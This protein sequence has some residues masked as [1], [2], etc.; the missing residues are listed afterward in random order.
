MYLCVP[1]DSY[2]IQLFSVQHVCAA[3]RARHAAHTPQPHTHAATI[4][5]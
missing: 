3:W 1:C 4:L 5:P 2:N